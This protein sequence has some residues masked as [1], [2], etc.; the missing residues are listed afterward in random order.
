MRTSDTQPAK[1]ANVTEEDAAKPGAVTDPVATANAGMKPAE[2]RDVAAKPVVAKL[3]EVKVAVAVEKR[4][5]VEI[6]AAKGGVVQVGPMAHV[7]ED[8]RCSIPSGSSIASTRTVTVRS[9][10]KSSQEVWNGC[11]LSVRP[12]ALVNDAAVPI[13]P[14]FV[15]APADLVA[16]DLE[17][18]HASEAVVLAAPMASGSDDAQRAP[19]RAKGG[20]DGQMVGARTANE[21]YGAK[22]RLSP[23]N[24]VSVPSTSTKP[25]FLMQ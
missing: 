20:P 16:V 5:E 2:G 22:I 12:V 15:V 25:G 19:L 9:A 13:V 18:A 10:A 23:K 3:A 14:V 7:M 17:T 6:R 4:G 1:L 24:L 21:R 8:A 11:V